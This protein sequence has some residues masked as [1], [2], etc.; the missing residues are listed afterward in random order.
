MFLI[1]QRQLQPLA[2]LMPLFG[3]EYTLYTNLSISRSAG[4]L[5]LGQLFIQG[6]IV[7]ARIRVNMQCWLDFPYINQW[8]TL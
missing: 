2:D 1:I 6:L 3:T 8:I 7:L 4:N 5:S